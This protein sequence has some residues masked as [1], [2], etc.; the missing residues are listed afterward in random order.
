M[1][2]LTAYSR[3]ERKQKVTHTQR[4]VETARAAFDIYPLEVRCRDIEHL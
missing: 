1:T 2:S 3:N 4:K